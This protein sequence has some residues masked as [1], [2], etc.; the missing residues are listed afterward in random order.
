MS[1]LPVGF[2]RTFLFQAC[3]ADLSR[4]RSR[5]PCPYRAQ[6][7]ARSA[8]TTLLRSSSPTFL[9]SPLMKMISFRRCTTQLRS[10]RQ[11]TTRNLLE[12]QFEKVALTKQYRSIAS[13]AAV[14]HFHSY[15]FLLL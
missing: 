4:A 8:T 12:R 10:L 7:A 11:T 15:W 3:R 14:L 1:C 13:I 6:R 5:Q 9:L 2:L